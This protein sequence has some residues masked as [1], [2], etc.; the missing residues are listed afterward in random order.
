MI[1]NTLEEVIHAKD[2]EDIIGLVRNYNM[3][4]N[5]TKCSFGVQTRKFLG[6]ML[7]N[8][9]IEANPDKFQAIIDMRRPFNVNEVQKLTRCLATL[10]CFLSYAGDKASNFFSMLKKNV[11]F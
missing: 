6:F 11:R 4:L 2:L 1:M 8:K 9:G 5:L 7:T 3:H 10:S